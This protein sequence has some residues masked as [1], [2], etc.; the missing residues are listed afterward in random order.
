M[1]TKFRFDEMFGAGITGPS[2]K[3]FQAKERPSIYRLRPY[4]RS[5]VIAIMRDGRILYCNDNCMWEMAP[6]EAERHEDFY[7]TELELPD[8]ITLDM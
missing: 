2:V 7:P 1:V 5:A 3:F 4:L 6:E 8:E